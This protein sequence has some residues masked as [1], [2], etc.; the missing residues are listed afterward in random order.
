MQSHNGMRLYELI[1]QGLGSIGYVGNLMHEDYKFA[2]LLGPEYMYE[3]T[4]RLDSSVPG[5][6]ET[7]W[8]SPLQEVW[9]ATGRLQRLGELAEIQRG[10]E[11]NL[12][13]R[14]N[15]E[16]LVAKQE[17]EGFVPGLHRCKETLEPFQIL[18]IVFLNSSAEFRRGSASTFD[19]HKPKLIVNASQIAGG[20]GALRRHRTTGD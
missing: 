6:E 4:G 20:I 1:K 8:L 17:R 10:I 18:K 13:F 12:P 9:K 5:F 2:E 15:E 19:W 14:W 11:Y 16:V 3:S 7:L